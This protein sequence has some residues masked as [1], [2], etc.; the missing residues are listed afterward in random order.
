MSQH[1]AGIDD[2]IEEGGEDTQAEVAEKKH[3]EVS[4]CK[5]GENDYSLR[6]GIL[7]PH[8]NFSTHRYG[9]PDLIIFGMT[10]EGMKELAYAILAVSIRIET[11]EK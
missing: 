4:Y 7:Y 11:L 10:P 6:L 9:G 2:V 3:V 8:T 5:Q 1:I